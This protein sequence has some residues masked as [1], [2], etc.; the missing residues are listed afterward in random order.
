MGAW[1]RM[2]LAVAH[3]IQSIAFPAVSCGVYGYPVEAAAQVALATTAAFLQTYR[4][5]LERRRASTALGSRA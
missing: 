4:R 2:E 3:G 1:Q 5:A